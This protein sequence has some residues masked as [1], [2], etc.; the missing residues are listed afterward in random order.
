MS[1]EY[2][3]TAFYA[4][5][6]WHNAQPANPEHPYLI[7][8]CLPPLNLRQINHRHYGSCLLVPLWN[9]QGVLRN[10]ERINDDG[11]KRGVAG[12]Q[13]KH[14]FYVYGSGKQPSYTIYIAEGWATAAAI[15]INKPCRPW[16][17]ACMSANNMRNVTEIA[18][19]LWP[20][21]SI[22]IA[23]DHDEPGIKTAV[24]VATE[25]DLKIILP[26]GWG[27]DFCDVH[28]QAMAGRAGQ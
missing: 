17:L 5:S 18:L 14:L 21:H 15:H 22:V 1:R 11:L 6:E 7:S 19:R 28:V 10:V 2:D 12:A 13:K 25:H 26:D 23:A 8:H 24:S 9:E 27:N 4:C 16:V 3:E 20:G